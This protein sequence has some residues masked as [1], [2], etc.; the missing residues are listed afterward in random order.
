VL[1]FDA[2]NIF[3][4]TWRAHMS[5]MIEVGRIIAM[6]EFFHLGYVVR[7]Q[8]KIQIVLGQFTE[9]SVDRVVDGIIH[10]GSHTHVV[11][12]FTLRDKIMRAMCDSPLTENSG[13]SYEYEAPRVPGVL[14]KE[15]LDSTDHLSTLTMIEIT[16]FPV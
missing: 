16:Y 13:Y 7:A 10:Y 11:P 4:R 2:N 15:V 6:S 1:F 14:F 3:G 8:E 5:Q 9:I 12:E